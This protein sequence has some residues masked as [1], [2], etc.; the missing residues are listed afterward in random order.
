M[1]KVLILLSVIIACN[2]TLD[3]ENCNAQWV[4]QYT[5]SQYA[6]LNKIQFVNDNIGYA[7]G[8]LS[9]LPKSVFLKTTNSGNNWINMNIVLSYPTDLIEMSFVNENTGYICGRSVNI[10]KT[11]N[12]GANWSTIQVPYWGNQ[13]WNSMQFL[14]ANTGY[15]AGRYGMIDKTTNGGVN[16]LALDTSYINNSSIYDLYFFNPTTGFIGDGGSVIRKTTNGGTNWVSTLLLDTIGSG[17]SLQKI[18][19]ANNN[20]GYVVGLNTVN[21]A[22]FKT[23]DNGNTW[24]NILISPYGLLCIK[25]VNSTTLYAGTIHNI[26]LYSTNSGTSWNYQTIP[27]NKGEIN[28]IY[29]TNATTGYLTIGNEIYR[30]TN[31]GVRVENISTEIPAAYSLSQNYPNPFNPTTVIKFCLSVAGNVVMKV[32]DVK[33]R[34]VETLVNERLKAGTYETM[35]DGS[36]LLSGVYYCRLEMNNNIIKTNKMILLK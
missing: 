17:Y 28:S 36:G 20:T 21:G 13:I 8:E 22:I 11:T 26:V 12:G 23:T 33:G 30:T 16:W 24:K 5:A 2:L 3:I 25:V 9:S 14:D 29:F 6:L 10:Y 31:G 18:D 4:Q 34:E 15:I 27:T 32:Y 1:K 19:F 7:V 35:F